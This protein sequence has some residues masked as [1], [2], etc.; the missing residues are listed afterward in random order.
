MLTAV[1]RDQ[2]SPDVVAGISAQFSKFAFVL[3]SYVTNHSGNIE[4]FGKQN[5]VMLSVKK[6]PSEEN[7]WMDGSPL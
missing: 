6:C 5:S 2:R 1:A 4:I 3:F 7:I